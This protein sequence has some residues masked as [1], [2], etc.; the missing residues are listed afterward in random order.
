MHPKG[1]DSMLVSRFNCRNTLV[2]S[3]WAT[4]VLL[5]TNGLRKKSS[6]LAQCPFSVGK[7]FSQSGLA[8]ASQD[9]GLLQGWLVNE[10]VWFESQMC[11][12]WLQEYLG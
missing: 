12:G 6:H 2:G 10:W 8:V 4:S 3:G 5:C 9:L 11:T 7:L 1:A